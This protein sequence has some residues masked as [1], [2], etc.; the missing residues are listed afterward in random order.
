MNIVSSYLHQGLTASLS[1]VSNMR[2]WFK[3]K[4][5]VF[6]MFDEIGPDILICQDSDI[7]DSIIQALKE[8]Q[9]TKLILIG[10]HIPEGLIPD[11]LCVPFELMDFQKKLLTETVPHVIILVNHANIAQYRKGNYNPKFESDI[12]YLTTNIEE[13]NL[14]TIE[15]LLHPNKDYKVK[16]CGINNIATPE[17]LGQINISQACDLMASTK[18]CMDFNGHITKDAATNKTFCLSNFEN[19]LFPYY[20]G[21][22]DM[23]KKIDKFLK[24]EKKRKQI[25]KKAY[26]TVIEDDTY[27]HKTIEIFEQLG[28]D[29][30]ARETEEILEKLCRES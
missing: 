14:D 8:Y 13:N 24:N 5:P 3:E 25:V 7:D 20:D 11:I 23:F 2:L 9:D 10:S 4:K 18:I 28:F 17:Y 22:E 19:D 21:V 12:L 27:L 1:L 30:Q 26:K 29:N 6:D 16:I 15:K